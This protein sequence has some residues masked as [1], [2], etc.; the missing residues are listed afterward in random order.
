MPAMGPMIGY[1]VTLIVKPSERSEKNPDNLLQYLEYM[2][3][4]KCR[5]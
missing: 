2:V 3:K 1:A 4:K 5:L